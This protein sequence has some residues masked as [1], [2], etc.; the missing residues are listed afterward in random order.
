VHLAGPYYANEKKYLRTASK[1]LVFFSA[2]Y[3][4]SNS[5]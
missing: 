5:T 2:S 1:T 3:G 4:F